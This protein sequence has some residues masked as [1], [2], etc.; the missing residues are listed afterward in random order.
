VNIYLA[1]PDVFRR[2]VLDWADAARQA[3][4]QLG[5]EALRPIDH[6]ERAAAGIFKAN[7]DLIDQAHI[8]VANLNPFRGAEPD[9][10]TCFELGVAV[11]RG[12]PVFGYVER[13]HTVAQRTA[14]HD[15]QPPTRYGRELLDRHGVRIEDFDLPCNLMIAVPATIIEGCLEDCLR[16]VRARLGTLA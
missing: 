11:A 15:G 1:G 9:S 4:R 13:L 14:H 8:V 10:G 6:L 7:L 5:F 12:K 3:C 16:A 2:D